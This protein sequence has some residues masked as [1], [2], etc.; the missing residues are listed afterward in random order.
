MEATNDFVN[1]SKVLV[2]RNV[3]LPPILPILEC[4]KVER[5]KKEKIERKNYRYSEDKKKKIGRKWTWKIWRE[6]G[7]ISNF[8]GLFLIIIPYKQAGT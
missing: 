6:S 4:I 3:N 2:G 7:Q 1:L 5:R 8:V